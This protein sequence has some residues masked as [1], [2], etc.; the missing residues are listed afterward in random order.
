MAQEERD[1]N[2]EADLDAATMSQLQDVKNMVLREIALR[3]KG[4][5][6]DDMDPRYDSHSS[7]HAKNGA[8]QQ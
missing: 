7:Y 3:V 6:N 8:P 2:I 5:E 1:L 4:K